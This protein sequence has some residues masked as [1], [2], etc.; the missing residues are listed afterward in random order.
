MKTY[1]QNA[2]LH[3]TE[4]VADNVVPGKDFFFSFKHCLLQ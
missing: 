1:D 2:A 4:Q 3:T